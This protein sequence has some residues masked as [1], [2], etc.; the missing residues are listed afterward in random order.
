MGKPYKCFQSQRH[1]TSRT[2]KIQRG[3]GKLLHAEQTS[4]NNGVLSLYLVSDLIEHLVMIMFVTLNEGQ[5]QSNYDVMHYHVS[6]IYHAKFGHDDVNSFRGIASDGPTHRH[7]D[8][9]L[10]YLPLF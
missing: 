6:G 8:F 10:V 7:A 4:V 9:G 3:K 1:G 2:V 5:S